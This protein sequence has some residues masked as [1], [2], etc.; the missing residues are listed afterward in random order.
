MLVLNGDLDESLN[1]M[2]MESGIELCTRFLPSHNDRLPRL[3]YAFHFIVAA[4]FRFAVKMQDIG[5]PEARRHEMR[6][7]P[8]YRGEKSANPIRR[9][10]APNG[11]RRWLGISILGPR[12]A[13]FYRTFMK[14]PSCLL[15]YFPRRSR[16]Q[17]RVGFMCMMNAN[18]APRHEP[19]R[20]EEVQ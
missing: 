20:I 14:N 16:W 7:K 6:S 1:Q 4:N 18:V 9:N 17:T 10:A 8:D 3:C 2:P 12:F 11:H 15:R 5:K 13:E 19:G